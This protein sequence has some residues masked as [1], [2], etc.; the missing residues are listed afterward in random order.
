M[1]TTEPKTEAPPSVLTH[2]ALPVR[3]LDDTLAFYR[4]YTT[5]ELIHERVDPETHLR[6]V[7]LANTA[8]KIGGGYDARG[9]SKDFGFGRLNAGKA[10]AA[11]E[12]T[13][14]RTRKPKKKPKRK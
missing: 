2:V 7:W 14:R 1:T 13:V 6:S 11:A 12:A 4:K 9:H 8:D 10:V 3:D 5:L